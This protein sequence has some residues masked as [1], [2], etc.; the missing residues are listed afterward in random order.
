M[1]RKFLRKIARVSTHSFTVN[2][3]KEL[4]RDFGWRERQRMELIADYENK[5]LIVKNWSSKPQ[6]DVQFIESEEN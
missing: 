5:E 6:N 4:M 3:P 1:Q 2:I